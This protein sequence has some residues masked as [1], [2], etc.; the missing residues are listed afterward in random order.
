M[1][2][3]RVDPLEQDGTQCLVVLQLLRGDHQPLWSREELEG[4]LYDVDSEAIDV[5]LE[6]LSEQQVVQQEGEQVWVSACTRHL[7]VLGFICI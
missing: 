4:E 6:R 3:E 5:A 1:A 2:E 7:D